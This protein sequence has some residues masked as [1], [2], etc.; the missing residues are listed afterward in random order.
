[1]K[2]VFGVLVWVFCLSSA[3]AQ[4]AGKIRFDAET[5]DFGNIR[6][7]NGSVEFRFEFTNAGTAPVAI[8]TVR[9]SCGCTTP[10][11]TREPVQ[12]GQKGFVTARYNPQ[13]RPGPFRK[14]LVVS[15]NGDPANVT[16]FIQGMVEGKPMTIENQYRNKIGDL[17]LKYRSFNMGKITTEKPVM[18][19]FDIYN[20][21]DRTM[22][23]LDRTEK[24]EH[25]TVSIQPPVL[26]PRQ[27]GKIVITYD[28]KAKNDLGFVSDQ[29]VLH[30]AERENARKE[31]L[32]VGTIEE[33]F[34]PMTAEQLANAPV[35]S[36][37]RS[38]HDFGTLKPAA[39]VNTEITLTNTGRSD[40]I[41]R[42]VKSNCSCA[43]TQLDRQTIRPGE[44]ATL[45][46]TFDSGSRRGNE[47]KSITIFSNDP[48]SPS[49]RLM[50][51]AVVGAV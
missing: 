15:T 32:I 48:R 2:A 43:T 3:I 16:L 13:N 27:E 12:P 17:R 4:Q 26:G 49:Q 39:M 44:K 50:L 47:Q 10:D 30:T 46:V 31:L 21:S 34:P 18:R 28:P 25:I 14:S 24:P 37:D 42:A 29:I 9:A 22:A 19:S 35:L 45:K 51:K 7:E 40:L 11:W 1:M 8:Q 36:L 38:T 41:I 33:Y 20:D 23:F 5:H 6:E